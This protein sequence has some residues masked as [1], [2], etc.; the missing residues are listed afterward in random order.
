MA[1]NR[2]CSS[3]QLSLFDKS[4]LNSLFGRT[5]PA[6]SLQ[7][8]EMIFV[9]SSKKSCRSPFLYLDTGA[10]QDWLTVETL[11]SLGDFS[12]LNTGESPNDVKESSLSQILQDDAPPKYYLTV[13]AKQN[14]LRAVQKHN[15]N[16]PN[17]LL[18][19]LAEILSTKA[20]TLN[21]SQPSCA[22][23]NPP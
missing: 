9:P 17:E 13:K 3:K 5:C 4:I 2:A 21:S 6:H 18:A 10:M 1:S 20:E 15:A 19:A 11:K 23:C 14:L 7:T 22:T 16:V 12:T 8:A